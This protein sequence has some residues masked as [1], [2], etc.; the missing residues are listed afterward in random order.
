MVIRF[1]GA[2]AATTYF[3]TAR[4]SN[5]SSTR[6]GSH[7]D[8]FYYPGLSSK[9]PR[10][11]SS[12]AMVVHPE[13]LPLPLARC[14]SIYVHRKA[15]RRCA[16]LSALSTLILTCTH[17][18]VDAVLDSSPRGPAPGHIESSVFQPADL[19]LGNGGKGGT[20][21]LYQAPWKWGPKLC[22]TVPPTRLK[23]RWC[24]QFWTESLTS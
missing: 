1:K 17:L 19:N 7:R 22:G 6:D 3:V 9:F 24:Y 11:A 21:P 13:L 5:V 16:A 18:V 8:P 2:V 20:A 14:N 23:G 10:K 12:M 4:Q 15:G